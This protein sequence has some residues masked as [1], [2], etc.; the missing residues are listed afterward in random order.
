[1]T[2]WVKFTV[3]IPDTHQDALVA[4]LSTAG[5]GGFVQ[6]DDYIDCYVEKKK[7]TSGVQTRSREVLQRFAKEYPKLELRTETTDVED[8]NWNAEWERS[9]GIVDATTKIVIK[10]SW[11]S[12]RRR[13]KGKIVLHIDPK[14]SFGTGHHETT[15]VCLRLMEYYVRRGDHVADFGTGTGVLAIAAAKLGASRVIAVDTDSWSFENASE[16]V[17]RNKAGD[18]ITVHKGSIVAL[19]KR[20]FD[21]VVANIDLPT[22]TKFLGRLL[23]LTRKGGVLILSGLLMT[24]L[25]PVL[26]LIN[27]RSITPLLLADEGEWIGF[28]LQRT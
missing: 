19:G 6:E 15:R 28:A 11:K 4:Q 22:I 16:N 27:R 20:P 24:D 9:A 10:P 14:M 25:V 18:R 23:T 3:S 2:S 12:L 21:L 17:L 5:F 8:R 1:M 13:D 7:W 26:R